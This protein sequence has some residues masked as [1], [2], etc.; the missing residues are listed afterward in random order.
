MSLSILRT[1]ALATVVAFAFA[2]GAAAGPAEDIIQKSKCNKCH[3]DKDTKKG[4]AWSSVAAKY[5]GKPDPT[6]QILEMFKT[7]GKDDHDIIKGSD[8]DLKAVIAIVLSS[9]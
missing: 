8:A 2:G 6:P 9:K 4:P 1:T 5:K 3:T 7:G